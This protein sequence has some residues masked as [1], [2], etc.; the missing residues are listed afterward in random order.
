MLSQI[1]ASLLPVKRRLRWQ[2]VC[3]HAAAGAV[4]GSALCALLAGT[5]LLLEWPVSVVGFEAAI[6]SPIA[7]GAVFGALI[8][9]SWKVAAH[10][11]DRHYRLKDR[12]ASALEFLNISCGPHHVLQIE[13]TLS[14]L[15]SV[16]AAAVVPVRVPRKLLWAFGCMVI[17]ASTLFVPLQGKPLEAAVTKRPVSIIEA[18]SEIRDQI[19]EMEGLAEETSVQ[20]LKDLVVR[21]KRDLKKLEEPETQLRDSLKTMTQMQQKM[22][23]MMDELDV[24]AVDSSLA[25]VAEAMGTAKAFKP[26]SDALKQQALK[27][28]ASALE[29]VNAEDMDRTE[30]LP[31]SEKLAKAAAEAEEKGLEKLSESLEELAE[32]VKA[33]DSAKTA[34]ASEK[35][36]TQIKQHD[37]AKSMDQMLSSKSE[38]LAAAK[39]KIAANS[40]SEG[41]GASANATGQNL[42]KGK[43]DSRSDA[44][45]RKAGSKS[46]GNIDGEKT[47]LDG[48]RHMARLTGQLTEAGDSEKE[49]IT[50]EDTDQRSQRLAQEAFTRYEKMSDAVLDGESIPLGHRETIKRYFELIRP[51]ARNA[52][53]E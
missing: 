41:S 4:V 34:A 25:E 9:Q 26:A 30:S 5:R 46:A 24:A 17:A 33:G 22:Q 53:S 49:T 42:A 48:E 18:A 10:A 32:S 31:T 14:H 23:A 36:A 15:Q 44:A 13:D 39:T 16:D 28:A 43:S 38:Q 20:P 2:R 35:L 21:L 47:R 50:G 19:E 45:S 51:A 11:V 3:S 29:N 27:K 8:R 7:I 1:H 52:I 40:N 37:L 12:T 6:F